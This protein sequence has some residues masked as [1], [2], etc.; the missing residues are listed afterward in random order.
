MLKIVQLQPTSI[1]LLILGTGELFAFSRGI[2]LYRKTHV[3]EYLYFSFLWLFAS[4]TSY[5]SVFILEGNETLILFQIRE[6]SFLFF[7]LSLS[8]HAQRRIFT[9]D[10]YILKVMVSLECLIVAT[11]SLVV[12]FW[13]KLPTIK[14]S[15]PPEPDFSIHYGIQWGSLVYS[16]LYPLFRNLFGFI[17]FLIT[18]FAYFFISSETELRNAKRALIL[19][20]ITA[21]GGIL[22][23]FFQTFWFLFFPTPSIRLPFALLA[24]IPLSIITFALPEG[25][26]TSY[27][28]IYRAAL[29]YRFIDQE[30]D[31]KELEDLRDYI[32]QVAQIIKLTRIK[33]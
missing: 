1:A 11:L 17:A 2:H 32:V 5:S 19:W 8:F 12:L 3:H 33:E 20:R 29:A 25:F 9:N 14:L 16:N 6:L 23:S 27:S 31:E 30:K 24:I 18:F 26:I 4:V 28:Q 15:I 7:F 22:W 21:V 10:H 13:R